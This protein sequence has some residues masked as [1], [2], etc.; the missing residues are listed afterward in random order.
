[1]PV[2]FRSLPLGVNLGIFAVAAAV[3]WIAGTRLGRY[4]DEIGDRTGLSQAFLGMM[5]LGV[6]T[7]LPEIATTLTAALIGNA[8]LVTANLFGGVALQIAILAIVDLI[9][10]RGALTYVTPKPVLLFQGVM[11]VLLL[12]IAMAGAAVGDPVSVTGVGLTPVLL[13]AGYV[14]TVRVTGT[15]KYLP[16]WRPAG[17]DAP[18]P[19]PD[20]SEGERER[21]G[22]SDRDD[23]EQEDV[24]NLRLAM[25][26]AAAAVTILTAGWTLTLTGNALAEQTGLGVSFVGVALVAASTSLPELSTTL[27][28]VRRGN[29]EMAV[30]NILGTNCLEVAL[31]LLADVAY[32]GGP[33]LAATNPSGMLAAA[34]GLVVTSLLLLGLLERRDST[35]G[36]MGVDSFAILIAYGTGLLGLFHLR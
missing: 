35:V 15:G 19:P 26:C 2:D 23:S 14:I 5:L 27:A 28:A 11:L 9:A 10:V 36:R 17:E 29:Y 4:A 8:Q 30:S 18:R 12:A 7:S 21:N 25:T 22:A 1:M 33:I 16:R 31:F 3:V 24:S 34:M 20:E 6:A 13:A 32:R